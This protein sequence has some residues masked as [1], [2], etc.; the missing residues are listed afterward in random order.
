MARIL[1]F[2]IAVCICAVCICAGPIASA[3]APQSSS[4]HP[5][6]A[7][8]LALVDRFM[9]AV[10]DKDPAAMAALR[11][12]GGFTITERPAPSGGTLI[13][14]RVFT[15]AAST[16]TTEYRERYWDPTVLVR[17]SIAV[18][19]TPYELWADGKTSHCGID[20]FDLLKE[21]GVWKIASAM[22]TVEPDACPALRPK[23]PSRIR[24]ARE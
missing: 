15:P 5:E 10:G 16:R 3:Q 7:A 2:I 9:L 23:D 24:P 18:V 21:Q 6:E 17:G 13:S 19:W 20:V 4:P 12:E 11:L 14:R 8:I 22:W 1:T